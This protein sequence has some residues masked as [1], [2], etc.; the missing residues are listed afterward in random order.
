M[1]TV[2]E[3]FCCK[4]N[5]RD[6]F[7]VARETVGGWRDGSTVK[8][9]DCSSESPEFKSQQPHGSSQPSVMGSDTLLGC[10]Q[11]IYTYIRR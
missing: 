2:I 4:M 6:L 5:Q 8:S 3:G 9:T 10:L 11:C 7:E 1:R